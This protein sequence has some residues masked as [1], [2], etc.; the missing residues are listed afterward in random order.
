MKTSLYFLIIFFLVGCATTETSAPPQKEIVKVETVVYKTL[1]IPDYVL[2]ERRVVKAHGEK[3]VLLT[4]KEVIALAEQYQKDQVPFAYWCGDKKY[5]TAAGAWIKKV[6]NRGR[7]DDR[8]IRFLDTLLKDLKHQNEQ[9]V[10]LNEK[11][12][13]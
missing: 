2:P 8:V 1:D 11:Q 9:Q 4:P 6:V 5:Y 7:E 12:T 10:L 3:L 13:E